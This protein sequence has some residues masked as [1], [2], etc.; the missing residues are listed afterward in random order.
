MVFPAQ[1]GRQKGLPGRNRTAFQEVV[2]GGTPTASKIAI[3]LGGGIA[4]RR[5]LGG[6]SGDTSRGVPRAR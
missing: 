6:S 1:S 4:N 5:L 3:P 2:G